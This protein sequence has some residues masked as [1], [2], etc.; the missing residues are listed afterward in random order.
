MG[1]GGNAT[2]SQGW[3]GTAWS[4]WVGSHT[5]TVFDRWFE[6]RSVVRVSYGGVYVILSS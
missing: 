5:H 6:L 2:T 1:H 4:P 3:Q